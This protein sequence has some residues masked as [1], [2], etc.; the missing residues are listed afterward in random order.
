MRHKQSYTR[1]ALGEQRQRY[2]YDLREGPDAMSDV[3]E[4]CPDHGGH[5]YKT[6]CGVTRCLYCRKVT[7]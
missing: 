5:T 7:G 2:D 3:A 6:Q 4:L 1:A